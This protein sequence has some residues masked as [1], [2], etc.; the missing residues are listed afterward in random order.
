[1]KGWYVAKSNARKENWLEKSLVQYNVEVYNPRIVVKKRGKQTTEP[2]FPTYLFCNFNPEGTDWP[3]IY[4]TPGLS[5]FLGGGGYPT[6]VSADLIDFIRQRVDNWNDGGYS[7]KHFKKG[8]AIRVA[9][10]PFAG[11]EAIFQGYIPSRQRCQIFVQIIG[12]LIPIELHQDD[13]AI[14]MSRA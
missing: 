8:E 3:S 4:R 6:Q 11:F 2:L 14:A 10:G 9:N 7:P 1:M 13:L 5:Y 12:R